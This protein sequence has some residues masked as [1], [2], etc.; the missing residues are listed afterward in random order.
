[1]EIEVGKYTIHS[2]RYCMW[3]TESVKTKRKDAKTEVIEKKVAGY[4]INAEQL[5]DSFIEYGVR[6]APSKT[7][8]TY[9][10]HVAKVERDA[11]RIA[12]EILNGTQD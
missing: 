5:L 3:I 9:L 4:S 7:I 1:M 10:K 2:D 8:E 12:K 6:D 11:K